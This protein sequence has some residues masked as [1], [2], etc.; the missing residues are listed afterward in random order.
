[1]DKQRQ[2]LGKGCYFAFGLYLLGVSA[3]GGGGGGSGDS[4][5]ATGDDIVFTLSWTGPPDLDLSVITPGGHRVSFTNTSV[6]GCVLDGDDGDR[7]GDLHETITCGGLAEG[8]YEAFVDN[9]D[10]SD[11]DA[12]LLIT[13][14]GV[15]LV[16]RS[17]GLSGSGSAGP[18]RVRVGSGNA[19]PVEGIEGAWREDRARLVSSTCVDELDDLFRELL[20]IANGIVIVERNGDAVTVEDSEGEVTLRGG[21]DGSTIDVDTTISESAGGC[22]VSVNVNLRVDLGDS[23]TAATYTLPWEFSGCPGFSDCRQVVET[24]WRR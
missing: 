21:V 4:A 1:M 16:D 10:P 11:V 17:L 7:E 14:G 2:N 12:T 6:D 8:N 19:P 24:R 20:P 15:V 9:L 18:F 23:P 5:T 3:C 22:S 13:S